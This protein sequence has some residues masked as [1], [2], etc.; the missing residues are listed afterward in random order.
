MVLAEENEPAD[1]LMAFFRR[2]WAR[3]LTALAR[4]D[5]AEAQPRAAHEV[6][7]DGLG[8]NHRHT[9]ADVDALA[10]LYERRDCPGEVERWRG[11]SS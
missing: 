4:F 2:T 1:V 10:D 6:H 3:C 5:E 7:T 11:V 8:P 9:Q